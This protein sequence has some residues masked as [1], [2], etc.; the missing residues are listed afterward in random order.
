MLRKDT[1]QPF[2]EGRRTVDASELAR[3]DALAEQW[4]NPDG[5]FKTVHNFNAARVSWICEFL[6]KNIGTSKSGQRPLVHRTILDVG[7]GAGL[8]TE[9]VAGLGAQVLAID[10]SAR[11]VAI[12]QRHESRRGLE[13]TYQCAT[14]E[15][16]EAEEPGFDAV[17]SLEVV[18]HVAN[19]PAFLSACSAQVRPGGYL[20]VGTLNRT[21]RSW[22]MAIMGAE[23]V[24][25]WLPRGTHDWRKFVKP[26]EL[27]EYLAPHG[28]SKHAQQGVVYNPLRLAWQLGRN[29]DVNYLIAFKKA[30]D[31]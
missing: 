27:I 5:Q 19:L 21:M 7:C 2:I 4:W 30:E 31:G 28:F 15:E 8:V 17:L 12:A 16:L 26:S 3:F 14:P 6:A 22:V 25:R 9:P 10:A 13:I 11:N 24:L 1:I 23:Y 29:T 20:I 18:E